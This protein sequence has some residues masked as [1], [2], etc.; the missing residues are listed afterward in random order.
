[1]SVETVVPVDWPSDPPAPAIE[2]ESRWRALGL[3]DGEWRLIRET[4]GRAPT[5]TE[6]GMFSVAWSEHCAYKHSRRALARLPAEGERLLMGPGESAGVLDIGGGW[7]LAVRLESHNH[8]SYVE[9]YQ[10]AATGVG[11]IVRDVLA[12]G[13]RPV[14]L[15][16]SLRFGLPGKPRNRYLFREVVAGIAGYGNAIGVPTVGG[17]VAFHESYDTNP[18]VN[19]MCVGLVRADRIARARADGPGNRVYLV[20][21]RTG[22]DGIHGAGL[23]AS[24]TFRAGEG[25]EQRPR[26]QVGDPFT[27]KLLIEACLEALETGAVVGI[28]DL[29]AAG[30]TAAS[31]ELAA[32]AGTGIDLDLDRV[33]R[34]EE[35]MTPFELM[36]SES[37]ERMMLVVQAGREAEVERI[38]RRYRLE[39][40]PIGVVDASGRLRVRCEGR[41]VADLP[42]RFLADGAP[43]Y[44]VPQPVRPPGTPTPSSASL[45]PGDAPSTQPPSTRPPVATAAGTAGR[46]LGRRLREAAASVAGGARAW[47]YEQFDHMVGLRT[48]LPPGHDAA[49]LRVLPDEAVPGGPPA[50]PAGMV[51]LSLDG[52]E[53]LA[54]WSPY[55]AG[56]EAVLEGAR[57][58]AAVGARPAG[59]TNGL[60]LGSPERPEVMQALADVVQGMADACRALGIPVT[61]G[62]VSLY[63]ETQDPAGTAGARAILPTPIVGMVGLVEAPRPVPSFFQRPGDVVV[64]VGRP[65]FLEAPEQ[66]SVDFDLERRAIELVVRAARQGLMR[67]CHDLGQGGS[68]RRWPRRPWAGSPEPTG[69]R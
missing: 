6:L 63:N 52:A 48:V 9:P 62:N 20:G 40:A 67:S 43:R 8:P 34:R 7:A 18:L 56:C 28:Q 68:P 29:G 11:G 65:A 42:A 21:A 35:G 33:P 10:G 54:G 51:A 30:I 69:A 50:G 16:D 57:N 19:V 36:L 15:L 47:I 38:F 23:L 17:E 41:L 25:G 5:W 1:M 22:R 49:V 12:A 32:R 31:S 59:I 13:A 55:A 44:D 26:V 24:R 4:L 58:V 3:T 14:A 39:A 66:W 46:V 27:E 45:P 2:A 64:L 53:W 37:Q 61:G 60:N